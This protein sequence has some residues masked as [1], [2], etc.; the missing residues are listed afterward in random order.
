MADL[1][2]RPN[3]A[4]PPPDLEELLRR[5]Q[6]RLQPLSSKGGYYERYDH[7]FRWWDRAFFGA[8]GLV[9]GALV[10]YLLG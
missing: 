8:L 3:G 6:E 1:H 10:G 4:T 2:A 7:V 5:G 9:V